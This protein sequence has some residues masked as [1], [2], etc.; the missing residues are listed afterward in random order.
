MGKIRQTLITLGIWIGIQLIVTVIFMIAGLAQGADMNTLI[1]SIM[2]PALLVSDALVVILLIAIRF[3]KF[4]EL[5]QKIPGDVFLVTMIF[6]LCTMFAVDMLAEPMNIPNVLEEQFSSM[7]KT[8]SGFLAICLIGPIME[9]IMMR[10]IIL[11]EMSKLTDSMWGG[12]LISALMFAVIHLNPAQVVFALPAGIVL[13]W[14]YCKT[15]SLMVPICIHILNNTISFLTIKL[16]SGVE[17]SFRITITNTLGLVIFC[18][19]VIISIGS[20]IWILK[21][22]SDQAKAQEAAM[23]QETPAVQTGQTGAK[24]AFKGDSYEK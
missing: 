12:I 6:G 11:T 18:V 5:F 2:A 14:L 16:D 1:N 13:G 20:L 10:R 8:L 24:G 4:K 9:E 15:R 23:T 7:T 17:D 21:Y 3:C 22:Y 19:L